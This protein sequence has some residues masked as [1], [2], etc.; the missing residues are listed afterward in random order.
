MTR[1]ELFTVVKCICYSFLKT[2]FTKFPSFILSNPLIYL[3]PEKGISFRGG[4]LGSPPRGGGCG[5]KQ[6]LFYV[7]NTLTQSLMVSSKAGC[8][9]SISSIMFAIE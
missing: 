6:Q 1:L 2:K 9:K 8:S 7:E 3:K 5:P 4:A